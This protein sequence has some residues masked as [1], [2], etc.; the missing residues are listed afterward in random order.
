MRGLRR[1]CLLGLVQPPDAAGTGP[2]VTE[3]LDRYLAIGNVGGGGGIADRHAPGQL[4]VQAVVDV[5]LELPPA[6]VTHD[7]EKGGEREGEG[8][9]E[10]QGKEGKEE[11]REEEQEKEKKKRKRRENGL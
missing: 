4:E 8:E 11:E 6:A 2:R 7:D 10:E 9:K 1:A 5:A 3:T